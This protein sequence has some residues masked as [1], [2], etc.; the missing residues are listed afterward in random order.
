MSRKKLFIAPPGSRK[1]RE[2]IFREILSLCPENDFSSVLY[3]CPNNFAINEAERDFHGYLKRPAYLP[4][5][6]A[7]LR[8]LAAKFQPDIKGKASDR[9]RAL[10]LCQLLGEKNAGFSKLLSDLYKKLKHYAPDKGLALLKDEIVSRIFEEKSAE[11]AS[12]AIDKLIAYEERLKKMEMADEAEILKLCIPL[13]TDQVRSRTLVIDGFFDPTPLEMKVIN[14]MIESSDNAFLLIEEESGIYRNLKSGNH[15]LS[16]E[17]LGSTI[18]RKSTGYY[19]YPSMEDEVESIA[20]TAKGLILEGADPWDIMVTFPSLKKY[21]PIVKRV[22]KKH[23]I[24]AVIEEHD[25][26]SSGPLFI[27]ESIFRCIEDDYPG[28]DL[29]SLLTSPYLSNTPPAVREWAVSYSYRAGIVKGKA[30][31]LSIKETL[32]NSASGRSAEEEKETILALQGGIK[33]VI[34]MVE[35]LRRSRTLTSFIEALEETLRR[36]GFFD[37]LSGRDADADNI[38]DILKTTFKEL[39]DF[40]ELYRPEARDAGSSI[41]YIRH[42]LKDIKGFTVSSGNVRVVP[43]ELVAGLEPEILFFGGAIEES[44]PSRPMIDPILPERVKKEIG[45]PSLEYSLSRQKR[46]FRRILNS[47]RMEPYFSCPSADGDNLLLPSPFL[48]WGSVLTAALPDIFTEENLLVMDGYRKGLEADSGNSMKSKET[49]KELSIRT[50]AVVGGHIS[51]TAID[52]Y[53]RCPQKFYI[54]R[55]L[56]LY[57]EEPPNFEVEAM[58]WGNLA[59]RTMEHLFKDGDVEPD[60]IEGKLFE[61]LEDALKKFPIG[62]FWA[63][64]AEEIFR[65]LLPLLIKQEAE[66]REEGF[67]PHEIEKKISAELDGLKLRGKI[68]RI[69]ISSQLSSQNKE[70]RTIRILDYKTGLPDKESLQLPLYALMWQKENPDTVEKVGVYSL[71][72]GKITWYP[73]KGGTD[74]YLKASLIKAEEI[75]SNIKKGIFPSEPQSAQECRFCFHSPICEGVK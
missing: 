15:K 68:D 56:G 54:E 43:F 46:Y 47:S 33:D 8:H 67:H 14:V 72:Q 61:G 29:L 50:S 51:V 34:E 9:M 74:E 58:L 36:S 22:F 48:E 19:S 10:I 73:S 7:T 38:A 6:S 57:I 69:D 27:I 4:F 40:D 18:N 20:K 52:S 2:H 24:P 66:I 1:K 35:G 25:L 60:R 26:S 30:S 3:I 13:L 55:I 23:G 62:S 28:H 65:T 44:L 41:F 31:W 37:S 75:A 11:R 16:A 71:R 64:V 17:K 21:I 53:R 70:D 42:L 39:K 5:E 49:L 59:H 32:L 63:S 12:G 45:L